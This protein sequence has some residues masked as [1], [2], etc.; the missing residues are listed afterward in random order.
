MFNYL[1]PQEVNEKGLNIEC[2]EK[3]PRKLSTIISP[4]VKTKR[5][6]PRKINSSQVSHKQKKTNLTNEKPEAKHEEGKADNIE[7]GKSLPQGNDL[8]KRY[9]TR[10]KRLDFSALIKGNKKT[11]TEHKPT[12]YATVKISNKL[13]EKG[14]SVFIGLN[15]DEKDSKS[16]LNNNANITVSEQNKEMVELKS[17]KSED[18]EDNSDLKSHKLE[19][20]GNKSGIKQNKNMLAKDDNMDVK[21]SQDE[22]PDV[23]V[24]FVPNVFMD[25][26]KNSAIKSEIKDHWSCMICQ[27]SQ[28]SSDS[29]LEHLLSDH[30]VHAPYICQVCDE[31]LATSELFLSHEHIVNFDHKTIFIKIHNCKKCDYSTPSLV[32]FD[33]HKDMN[34]QLKP[35]CDVC[36]KKFARKMHLKTHMQAVHTKS[37]EAACHVCGKKFA[38]VVYMKS[39]MLRHFPERNHAC[40]ICH[41]RFF[42][43]K[44]L[45]DHAETHKPQDQ[46]R[47][48]Y[49]C[50]FCSKKFLNKTQYTEHQTK[51][52]GH[53]IF[54]CDICGKQFGFRSSVEKHKMFVHST[55]RP[56]TCTVCPKSFKMQRHL[57]Q[58]MVLHT[59]KSDFTCTTCGRP[60]SCKETLKGHV[61]KCKG[62]FSLT[63]KFNDK[64]VWSDNMI[65][66]LNAPQA[67]TGSDN[68][69]NIQ[70]IMLEAP[71]IGD[72]ITTMQEIPI[73]TIALNIPESSDLEQQT[74]SLLNFE[75]STG[76]KSET[77]VEDG[78]QAPTMYVCS[79]CEEMFDNFTDAEK[80]VL[81]DHSDTMAQGQHRTDTMTQG[82][83]HADT[84]AQGQNHA[85]TMVQGQNHADTM[86]QRQNQTESIPQ[87][88]N[89]TE[90]MAQESNHTDL[91]SPVTNQND[92]I[93][94]QAELNMNGGNLQQTYFLAEDILPTSIKEEQK[95]EESS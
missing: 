22:K 74:Q 94:E 92:M 49:Q 23:P 24:V 56:Y 46:R 10:G 70:N 68:V 75:G 18:K 36:G 86:A 95:L 59:G 3:S 26:K 41:S 28:E 1:S 66:T 42:D 16:C 29:Y 5:G 9:K 89:Q 64:G 48:R 81:Q 67:A 12:K 45:L 19:D 7:D 32:E 79:E 11:K 90:N 47:F 83:H 85:D 91:V 76:N 82:Q 50:S 84:M 72:G 52:T 57:D 34:H 6:R 30:N 20:K 62:L 37:R 44:T 15:K 58:H 55:H 93:Q 63:H 27:K 43:K 2:E 33:K 13:S 51:H 54:S 4:P 25:L 71:H 17:H 38:H 69:V 53:K 73:Q 35:V 14:E 80:H 65:I 39:H 31:I 21:D 61:P 8:S 60:F 40:D 78:V 88:Q 87:G 77:A